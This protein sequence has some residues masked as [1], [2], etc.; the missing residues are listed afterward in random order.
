MIVQPAQ[1]VGRAVADARPFGVASLLLRTVRH[2][3][4]ALLAR[5]IA[6]S[7]LTRGMRSCS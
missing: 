3:K 4:A 1:V 7:R 5:D 6:C 2:M